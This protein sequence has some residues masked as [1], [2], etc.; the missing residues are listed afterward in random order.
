MDIAPASF[1]IMAILSLWSLLDRMS[2]NMVVLP[3]PRKPVK[4]VTDGDNR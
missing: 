2:F 3:L 1:S 4:T